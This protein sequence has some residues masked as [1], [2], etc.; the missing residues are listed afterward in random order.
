VNGTVLLQNQ[1][2]QVLKKATEL[3]NFPDKEEVTMKA[4]I[5]FLLLITPAALS[6]QSL[7]EAPEGV[8]YDTLHHR[9]LVVNT[10][11]SI[12]AIDSAGNHDTFLQVTGLPMDLCIV[13]NVLYISLNFPMRLAGYDLLSDSLLV[14]ISINE[15][16]GL[17]GIAADTCGGLYVV[18]QSGKIYNV[19]VPGGSYSTLITVGAVVGTP[20]DIW[21]EP[22]T[23]CLWL[24]GW[25]VMSSI[26]AV[27]INTLT[28]SPLAA[29]A[30]MNL[31]ITR[32]RYENTYISSWLT[33][34]VY[35][36][37]PLLTE[38]PDTFS[39]P[40]NNPTGLCFTAHD[41]MLAIANYGSNSVDFRHVMLEM[42]A[43]DSLGC[44]P[45]GVRFW[46]SARL[47]VDSWSW[48]FGDGDTAFTRT[49][50]H[51]YTQAGA[52][53][54]TLRVDI[55][56]ST[57]FSYT[58]NGF[59]TV[60]ADSINGT[61]AAGAHGTTVELTVN[62]VNSIPLHE[63]VLPVVYEGPI[64]LT[65]GGWSIAGCR[66]EHFD[67]VRFLH[68]NN[69]LKQV[70]IRLEAGAAAPL[71]PG[72]G[73]I[74]K[75]SFVIGDGDPFDS[76]PVDFAGYAGYVPGF[77]GTSGSYEPCTGSGAI[78]LLGCCVGNMGNVDCEGIVDIGDVTELIALLF[79]RVG[80]PFCCE[81]EADLDYNGDIDI[82]DLAILTNRLFITVTD[83]PPCPQG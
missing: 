68:V 20:Q 6:G 25:G 21:Y 3:V 50:F 14:E 65:F 40:H 9:Y 51:T 72:D 70:T 48:T 13:G 12:I 17:N 55:N 74:I 81:D 57:A 1:G 49:P 37:D 19:D 7:L 67:D 66:T 24:V 76:T 33:N 16:A 30:G 78:S 53:D 29:T 42:G 80:D 47:P 27:D 56:D 8:I 52:Y 43:S 59:I 36:F 32:D 73:A 54:V 79:I 18:G 5:L 2:I 26:M 15:M 31:C 23:H 22:A 11:G 60:V 44:L 82:G 63:L 58:K 46:G 69:S 61:E 10:T 64:D 83:P 28:M 35:V 62:A 41:D 71:P 34:C 75:F 77:S 39:S 45:L 38:P 4:F